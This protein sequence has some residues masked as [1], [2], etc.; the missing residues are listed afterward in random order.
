[1]RSVPAN[2]KGILHSSR[3]ALL[4]IGRRIPLL[5]K[6]ANTPIGIRVLRVIGPMLLEQHPDVAY[7]IWREARLRIRSGMYKV[8]LEP[9][10][11]TLAT[12]AWNTPV[13][14][15]D[16]L[17]QSVFGQ[18]YGAFEW[19]VLDNGSTNPDTVKYLS[20]LDLD[21][22]VKLFRVEENLGIIGGMRFCLERATGRYVLPVDSDDY[23][24]PDCLRVMAW[25]ISDKGYPPLLY[26][27]EDFLQG[28]TYHTPSLKPGWDPVFFV[29]ACYI[30]HLCAIDRN[31]AAK[32]GAYTDPGVN[33]CHDWDTFI[34]FWMAGHV[35]E[36]V[37][38]ILYSW[39]MHPSSAAMNINSKSYIYSSQQRALERY[40]ASQPHPGRYRVEPDA[41]LKRYP[42]PEWHFRR[43]RVEP[44]PLISVVLS[45]DP[46][47][48][49]VRGLL[50]AA[51][52]PLH[53][54]VTIA[55]SSEPSAI[56][57]VAEQAAVE[58]GLIHFVFDGVRITGDDWPWEVLTLTELHSDAVMVGGRVLDGAQRIASAGEYFGVGGDC[59]CP[60]LGRSLDDL[61]YLG[62]M[63]KQHSVSAVSTM[64]SVVDAAFLLEFLD[65]A[66]S[67]RMSLPFLG[68]WIGAYA[69]RKGRRVVY[70]PHLTGH[71]RLPGHKVDSLVG[72]GERADFARANWDV[73][74]DTR[75]LSSLLS[76]DPEKPYA[77]SSEKE[78]KAFLRKI[79]V[80][81]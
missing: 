55:L 7:P 43:S 8:R 16:V 44:R 76:L 15:L 9:G 3:Q 22:R 32:V 56:R 52:Y 70:T 54:V 30:A 21:P 77:L 71:T 50:K 34:R 65:K 51:A 53:K 24:C 33:G 6:A 25:H 13:R 36:H 20:K 29:K 27:D 79:T 57:P 64:L 31:L 74:P 59:R 81:L 14:Y 63:W 73:I 58:A 42:V 5:R 41:L 61:G 17:S 12:C 11:L 40:L 23:L 78:R 35:P 72:S 69:L 47:R 45:S 10:L 48:V 19:V 38:E 26:S 2:Q 60:D 66:Q 80:N 49:D 62:Q 39:R 28:D 46:D 4:S 37:P 18:D 68:A 1:M 67:P 75:F